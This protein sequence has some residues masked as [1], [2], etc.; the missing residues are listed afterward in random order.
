M[1][2]YA[3]DKP[4]GITSHDVVSRAR[5]L[6]GTKRVGHAGTLDPLATGVLIVMAN[7]ATKLSGYLTGHDKTYLAWVTLGATTPTLDAEGPVT[8]VADANRVTEEVLRTAATRFLEMRAQ[9]PPA[10]S[11][12]R[13]GGVRSYAAARRG[14][15]EEPPAR[16]VAYHEVILL[17]V[18]GS[19]ADLPSAFSVP[20]GAPPGRYEPSTNGRSFVLPAPPALGEDIASG[21][22]VPP[23]RTA[24]F[25]LVVGAGTYVRS[26]ARDLGAAIGLPAYLS[27]LVRTASGV[28]DL[29]LASDLESLLTADRLDPVAALELPTVVLTEQQ[30]VDVRHGKR[31]RLE[32][33]GRE[34]R[35][36]MVGQ[37]GRLVAVAERGEGDD[38]YRTLRVFN[39]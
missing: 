19:I 17:G 6:L 24:L 23:T 37:D 35:V 36:A 14:T 31:P 13:R 32:V 26:F 3:V 10:Y 21:S 12:V 4:L 33:E 30:A 18:S 15:P 22:E 27:G 2:L 16:S 5:R 38:D 1:Q 34:A 20:E 11:A 29:G 39:P 8:R 9:R 25:R 7:E 28:V